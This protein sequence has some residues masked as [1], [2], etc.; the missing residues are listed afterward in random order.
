VESRNRPREAAGESEE[1]AAPK[2]ESKAKED[3]L[4]NDPAQAL[5]VAGQTVEYAT[6]AL[7]AMSV[8]A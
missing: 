5:E 6:E 4:A 3:E 2:G 1:E 7:D 8:R